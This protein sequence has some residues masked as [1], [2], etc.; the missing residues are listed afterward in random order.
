MSVTL[1][2]Y[3]DLYSSE[4]CVNQRTRVLYTIGITC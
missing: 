4:I 1:A 2:M 3:M